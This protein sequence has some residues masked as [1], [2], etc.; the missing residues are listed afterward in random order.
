MGYDLRRGLH[1][2]GDQPPQGGTALDA[3]RVLGRVRRARAARAA[4]VGVTSAAAVLGLTLA[5][6]AFP[7]TDDGPRPGPAATS[8]PAPTPTP[9]AT[10]EQTPT[11]APTSTLEPTQAPPPVVPLVAVTAE[12]DVVTLDPAT[13]E[14]LATLYSGID[15][16]DGMVGVTMDHERGVVYVAQRPADGQAKGEILRIPVGGA[17]ELLLARAWSP[18]LSPD[19]T[20]LVA[21]AVDPESNASSLAF[22]DLASGDVRYLTQGSDSAGLWLNPHSW[23][24]DGATLYLNIGVEES[25]GL[26][27]LPVGATSL[28]EAGLIPSSEGEE[29]E[30]TVPVGPDLLAVSVRGEGWEPADETF[31]LRLVDR[32]SGSPVDEIDGMRG[33]WARD[34][35]ATRDGG[36]V[37]LAG[38][39]SAPT[40]EL[41]YDG[42][43]RWD[44]AEGLV[45]LTEGIVAVGG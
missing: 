44:G 27:T 7:L 4:A 13:G 26:R 29:W 40:P 25:S 12:G 37:V 16:G 33:R 28:D 34:L 1:D 15:V 11:Q 41:T 31:G 21:H 14:R 36:L 18:L 39:W 19:G 43:Y 32:V 9:T 17:A 45:L 2:L 23:S 22:V 38:T 8:E 30:Q 24:P 10:P 3:D 42:L 6:Q 35:V 20:F 5:V